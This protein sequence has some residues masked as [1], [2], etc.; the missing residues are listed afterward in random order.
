MHNLKVE[1][2]APHSFALADEGMRVLLFHVVRELLFNVVKHGNASRAKI[3]LTEADHQVCI[4]ISDDGMGFD[5]EAV[6]DPTEKGYGLFHV[7][8]RLDLF[9]GRMDIESA[10]GEGT[11]VSICAPIHPKRKDSFPAP[12]KRESS[13]HE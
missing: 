13:D 11:R 10:P 4:E 1:I 8:E 9:G 7:R 3:K 2:D 12:A 6:D 5:V